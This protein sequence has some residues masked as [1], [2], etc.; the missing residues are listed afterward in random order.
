MKRCRHAT[1][2]AGAPAQ[3]LNF[4]AQLFDELSTPNSVI[5]QHK[6]SFELWRCAAAV[7]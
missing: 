4:G 1:R 6:R 3:T 2:M 7:R 5:C